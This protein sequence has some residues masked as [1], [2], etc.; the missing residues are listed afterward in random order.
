MSQ[1]S[2]KVIEF[3]SEVSSHKTVNNK[4]WKLINLYYDYLMLATQIYM[5]KAWH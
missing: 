1:V 3:S 4:P 5:H 2:E